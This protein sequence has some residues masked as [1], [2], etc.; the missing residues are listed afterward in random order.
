MS[1]KLIPLIIGV[2]TLLTLGGCTT[3]STGTHGSDYLKIY[4]AKNQ[5][6]Y[7]V[8]GKQSRTIVARIPQNYNNLSKQK[9][10]ANARPSYRY[11]MHHAKHDV[12]LTIQVYA[13]TRYAKL[14]GVPVVGGGVVKLNQKNYH[15]LSHPQKYMTD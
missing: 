13:N 3:I 8:T 14:S 2:P 4:N 5:Q 9:I 10:P 7:A 1:H 12:K 6:I 15:K 11:V